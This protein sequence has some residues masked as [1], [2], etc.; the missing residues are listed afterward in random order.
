MT[1]T[2]DTKAFKRSTALRLLSIEGITPMTELSSEFQELFNLDSGDIDTFVQ[3]LFFL[4]DNAEDKEALEA[5]F[6]A[7]GIDALMLE[8]LRERRNA[9][10]Y[11]RH[12]EHWDVSD[13]G[14]VEIHEIRGFNI[15]ASTYD[16]AVKVRK[17]A[18]ARRELAAV[19]REAAS[20]QCVPTNV[21]RMLNVAANKA[22]PRD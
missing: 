9:L 2:T 5:A 7:L 14:I 21:R 13:S 16:F 12:G 20:L 15:I 11:K 10:L 18:E 19:A 17:E 1:T 3:N 6:Y 8:G 22:D 4:R